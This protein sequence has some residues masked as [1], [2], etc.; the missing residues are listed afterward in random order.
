[1]DNYI[2]YSKNIYKPT[3]IYYV[4]RQD[5]N[6]KCQEISDYLGNVV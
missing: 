1:M 4:Q 5:L 6:W 3:C 2:R